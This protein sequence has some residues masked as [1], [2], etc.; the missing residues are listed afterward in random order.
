VVV[1]L[2]DSDG[3]DAG[4]A[5]AEGRR[6]KPCSA[7]VQTS[8]KART[9]PNPIQ[10]FGVDHDAAVTHA[11]PEVM[12]PSASSRTRS[13]SRIRSC[14]AS[15]GAW[16]APLRA[17][18]G[19]AQRHHVPEA[20]NQLYEGKE[21]RFQELIIHAAFSHSYNVWITTEKGEWH[22]SL[23]TECVLGVRRERGAR[24]DRA[25]LTCK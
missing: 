25:S 4:L 12:A 18:A 10:T 13:R 9:Q 22:L 19:G 2:S 11:I 3:Q 16:R 20:L 15:A 6:S 7:S 8:D 14:N 17:C 21:R 24:G 23:R 5:Q 1:L